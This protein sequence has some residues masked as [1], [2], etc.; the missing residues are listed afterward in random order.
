MINQVITQARRMSL[1]AAVVTFPVHPR[2]VMQASFQ[3]ELLNTVTEKLELLNH[4]GIDRCILLDFTIE[5]SRLSAKEFMA[6]LQKEYRVQAL[7]IG[8]DHR[9]GHNR[10]EGFDDYVA[11]GNEM[12]MKVIPARALSVDSQHSSLTVSSSIIRHFLKE[13][14][15]AEAEQ[16][17]DYPYSLSGTVVGGY[18]V[19]R[20]LGF[21]TANLQV[22]NPDKLIPGDGVYAVR[23]WV[24]GAVRGGM[25]DIGNR[26]TFD[27]GNQRSIEVH[28]FDFKADIYGAPMRI[29]F[30][31]RVRDDLKFES[32]DALVA[33]LQRD[34]IHIRQ[35]LKNRLQS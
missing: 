27:D 32:V 34:E 15:V 9:F 14:R 4:T 6:L 17:L 29:S 35:L 25:L 21:P 13:G 23:V 11:Y 31:E 3:P 7:V 12:G 1:D 5:L 2:K 33:Q 10:A 30:V 26:P 28:I 8:Y 19:G 22:D 20:T 24:D 18:R 16:C